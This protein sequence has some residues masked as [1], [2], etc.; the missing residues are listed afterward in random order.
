MKTTAL[1]FFL[2]AGTLFAGE[3]SFSPDFTSA[4]L[5]QLAQALGDAL[6]F[7]NLTSARASGLLGF[8]IMGVLGGTQVSEGES[9]RRNSRG[10]GNT[11][12]L[13]AAPRILLRKGLPGR[14]DIGLQVGELAGERFFGGEARWALFQGNVALPAAAVVASFTRLDHEVLNFRL[15]ELK[16]LISKGFLVLTPFAGVGVQ[17][18]KAEALFGKTVP[19]WHEA[20]SEGA[21]GFAGMVVRPL[22]AFR[23]V[24]EAKKG[25]STSYFVGFGVGL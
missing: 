11:L 4:H 25:F 23:I 5:R 12:G 8:E 1:A 14:V 22:P 9:W 24:V 2:T 6:A 3:I 13:L 10:L 20:K 16:F 18:Y 7:P 19:S 15:A 17:R 21:V